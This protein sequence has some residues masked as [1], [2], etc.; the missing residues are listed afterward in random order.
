LR[1]GI[2]QDVETGASAK[3]Q[4]DHRGKRQQPEGDRRQQ[5]PVDGESEKIDQPERQRGPGAELF[6]G[7]QRQAG[8]ERQ[9]KSE[10]EPEKQGQALD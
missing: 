1:P 8:G 7:A 10:D 6:I 2:P 3:D 5:Q 9:S 4:R